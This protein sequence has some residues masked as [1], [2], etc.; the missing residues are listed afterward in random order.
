MKNIIIAILISIV[1][2]SCKS[3]V[4]V[5]DA[6]VVEKWDN[7]N[8]KITKEI[9]N[10]AEDKFVVTEFYRDGNLKNKTNYKAGKLDGVVKFFDEDGY[11]STE[12]YYKAGMLESEYNYK[13]G[14]LNGPEKIYHSNGQLWTERTLY[15]GLPWE[16]VSNFDSLGKPMDP[17]TL[18]E[19]FGTINLYDAKGNLKETKKYKEGLE[20]ITK[21]QLNSEKK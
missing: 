1:L 2:F 11:L 19:G 8:P 4:N 21:E 10:K 9:I 6:N 14:K 7:G 3:K 13:F 12:K 15:N 5:Q 16:V 18:K 20:I 17:G